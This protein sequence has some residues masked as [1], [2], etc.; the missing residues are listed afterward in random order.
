MLPPARKVYK[1]DVQGA[2]AFVSRLATASSNE[3]RKWVVKTCNREPWAEYTIPPV[4]MWETLVTSKRVRIGA[5][6]SLTDP[7]P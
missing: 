3:A 1:P 6:I 4:E 2:R 7:P 5:T